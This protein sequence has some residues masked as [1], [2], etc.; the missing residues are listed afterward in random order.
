MQDHANHSRKSLTR[1]IRI[2][3]TTVQNLIGLAEKEKTSVNQIIGS[4]LRRYT[5]WRSIADKVG[6]VEVHDKTL[7]LIFDRMS[8]NEAREIGRRVGQSA[9]CESIV[10][11]YK[12][13]TYE[14]FLEL[15]QRRGQFGHWFIVEKSEIGDTD[16]LILNHTFGRNTTFFLSEAVA[17]VL[18][19]TGVKFER[20]ESEGQVLV[21]VNLKSRPVA[22][23]EKKLSIP[24]LRI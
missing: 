19:N 16:I 14:N 6:M 21:R 9:W 18:E 7:R 12:D 3:E 15:L 24:S 2:D 23:M 10:Y 13:L 22:T 8:E 5:D 4:A 17:A 1:T 20:E 11:A